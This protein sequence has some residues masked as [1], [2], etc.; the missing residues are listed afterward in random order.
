[1]QLRFR[2]TRAPDEIDGVAIPYDKARRGT[3]R[4]AWYLIL[5]L[6]LSPILYLGMRTLAASFTRTANGSVVLDELQISASETARVSAL[7]VHAGDR[8]AAGETLATLDSA[9]LDA[10]LAR[11]AAQRA[12]LR[13]QIRGAGAARTAIG[14][15]LV[16]LN[17]SALYQRERRAAVYELFRRGAA[18]R[19]ELDAAT[20][21]LIAA[22]TAVL[23][24]RRGLLAQTPAAD[25]ASAER[26]VLQ[27][28]LEALTVR[29]P[30]NGRVLAVLVKPGQYV[31]SGDPLIVVARLDAPRVI[32]YVSP[33]FATRLTIGATAT[34]YFP[35]GTR[36]RTRIA[37][38]PRLTARMPP[39]LV[40]QFGLRPMTIV[41]QLLPR[42]RWPRAERVAGLPV[43]VRFESPW[44]NTAVGSRLGRAVGWFAH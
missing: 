23:Q 16:L 2:R 1:M 18:T 42:Q 17:R 32:A 38:T 43:V 13:A 37:T 19:A 6:V 5:G 15:E 8:I 41:L 24:A 29:A 22:E 33:K 28:R 10:A 21:D 40:D 9:D 12:G 27:E 20:A 4:L 35:D 36:L 34:V 39:D 7:A 11:N 26:S 14:R 30:F 44:E 25:P 31:A 3:H